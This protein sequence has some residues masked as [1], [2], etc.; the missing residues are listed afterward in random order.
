MATGGDF[1]RLAGGQAGDKRQ[2]KAVKDGQAGELRP[3]CRLF[4]RQLSV[5]L[6]ALRPSCA[7][8]MPGRGD[9]G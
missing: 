6:V 2:S 1:G 7:R 8:F 4:E 3:V 5:I 9:V